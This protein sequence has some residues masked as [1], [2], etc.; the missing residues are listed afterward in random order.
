API[1]FSVH[2]A[3]DP[4]FFDLSASGDTSLTTLDGVD[5][6]FADDTVRGTGNGRRGGDGLA[7]NALNQKPLTLGIDWDAHLCDLNGNLASPR[8]RWPP[9]GP[10]GW[11]PPPGRHGGLAGL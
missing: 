10:L 9:G 4:T 3:S 11:G 8:R 1:T 2:F 5:A 7:V 6:V